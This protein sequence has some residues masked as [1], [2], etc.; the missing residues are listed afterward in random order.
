MA[1][2]G[3]FLVPRDLSE[4][5]VALSGWQ[6]VI[7]RFDLAVALGLFSAFAVAYVVF[8]DARP[9]IAKWQGARRKGLEVHSEIAWAS[10]MA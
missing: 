9:L 4:I 6:G 8:I 2:V 10:G 7:A 3:L 1:L 5:P